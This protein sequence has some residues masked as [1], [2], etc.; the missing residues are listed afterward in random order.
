MDFENAGF[1]R[2]LPNR[3]QI[4]GY[5]QLRRVA[6]NP[7]VLAGHE[8]RHVLRDSRFF[9]KVIRK[10]R[11]R[12][13]AG[14][15]FP[16][17]CRERGVAA[18]EAAIRFASAPI[19]R[20]CAAVGGSAALRMRHTPCGCRSAHLVGVRSN[21]RLPP[22]PSMR[23]AQQCRYFARSLPPRKRHS[24]LTTVRRGCCQITTRRDSWRSHVHRTHTAPRVQFFKLQTA[25]VRGQGARP[26]AFSWGSKG[27]IL[28][29]ERISPLS[30][31]PHGVGKSRSLFGLLPLRAMRGK[32]EDFSFE[33][34]SLFT[35][36]L[37][38]RSNYSASCI[39]F[40]AATAFA[41]ASAEH[42][43]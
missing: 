24:R 2:K 34:P 5:V 37:L 30:A 15:L 31:A 6:W 41:C 20:C 10:T 26:L 7:P 36:F 42:C 9:Q 4:Q 23:R 35:Y 28:S 43:S 14:L 32:R 29:R 11:L 17:P 33:K 25:N 21:F 19:I 16:A 27:D 8:G 40:A 12:L 3:L 39:A 18:F 1:P 38:C 22:V 13:Q